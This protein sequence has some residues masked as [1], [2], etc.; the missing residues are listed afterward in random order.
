MSLDTNLRQM[1]LEEFFPQ[2]KSTKSEAE[3]LPKLESS[4]GMNTISPSTLASILKNE[5]PLN[6]FVILDCRFDYEYEGG[7]IEGAVHIKDTEAL[8]EFL[9]GKDWESSPII[10]H[11][12]F[13]QLRG[14]NMLKWLRNH[15]RSQN[16]E[17]YPNLYYPELYLMQGGYAGFFKEFPEFCVPSQYV[18]CRTRKMKKA[19][20]DIKIREKIM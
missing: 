10:I 12:E 18:P 8:L 20:T 14:P 9:E 19:L 4:I 1:K 7:H 6:K 5:L 2:K 3:I 16:I 15:D 11:C 13:S 17:N